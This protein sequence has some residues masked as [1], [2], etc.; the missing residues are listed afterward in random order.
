LQLVI[1]H[2]NKQEP[3]TNSELPPAGLPVQLPPILPVS[4]PPPSA[5]QPLPPPPTRDVVL[6]AF[7]ECG[8][9]N[10]GSHSPPAGPPSALVRRCSGRG[11]N[12]VHPPGALHR[13]PCGHDLC[14]ACLGRIALEA[15]AL[16]TRTWQDALRP[17]RDE[18]CALRRQSDEAR[19]GDNPSRRKL[20]AR[21]DVLDRSVLRA[22]GM[23]CCGE[24]LRLE[25][26]AGC[27]EPA[28]ARVWHVLTE[29]MLRPTS[30]VY[31]CS[32]ISCRAL[33]PTVSRLVA[34]GRGSLAPVRVYHC[35]ACGRNE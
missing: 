12:K 15:R 21:A 28:E 18:I 35:I 13:L 4:P 32:W 5:D 3:K 16:M 14:R 23:T 19:P 29:V 17:V 31:V 33:V 1:M 27:M 8:A 30:E 22:A 26:W 11:C 2:P 7:R 34:G 9:G 25:R 6:Q 24:P 10:C 20:R